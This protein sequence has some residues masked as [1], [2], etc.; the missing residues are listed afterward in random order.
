MLIHYFPCFLQGHGERY[1][2]LHCNTDLTVSSPMGFLLEFSAVFIDALLALT[3]F[4]PFFVIEIAS[5]IF[6]GTLMVLA[7]TSSINCVLLT[8]MAL[9]LHVFSFV[10]HCDGCIKFRLMF[11]AD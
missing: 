9:F 10:C 2:K 6:L 5:K 8:H 4:T 1:T 11:A 7:G 3:T